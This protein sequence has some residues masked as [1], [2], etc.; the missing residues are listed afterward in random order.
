MAR[1]IVRVMLVVRTG[2]HPE[3][4]GLTEQ[5]VVLDVQVAS[6]AVWEA[7]VLPALGRHSGIQTVGACTTSDMWR[8]FWNQD[9]TRRQKKRGHTESHKRFLGAKP[10][11]CALYFHRH[12]KGQNSRSP[13]TRLSEPLTSLCHI[14]GCDVKTGTQAWALDL[15]LQ[16]GKPGCIVWVFVTMWIQSVFCLFFSHTCYKMAA[17]AAPCVESE[18]FLLFFHFIFAVTVRVSAS[19]AIIRYFH[20]S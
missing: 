18:K 20:S 8:S 7:M 11:N 4:R 13:L 17:P 3:P 6:I 12:T 19:R 5:N 15:V 10:G 1:C 2:K 9:L 16:W 14:D